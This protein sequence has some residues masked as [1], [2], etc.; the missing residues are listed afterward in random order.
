M[1]F[2]P[3][4]EIRIYLPNSGELFVE[5]FSDSVLLFGTPSAL[6]AACGL[7]W[8]VVDQSEFHDAR[9]TLWKFVPDDP[10]RPNLLHRISP[11][12]GT[13]ILTESV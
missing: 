6:A 4:F 10:L 13:H 12:S 8:P 2:R 7:Q 11:L 1:V 9:I 5:H 3:Y